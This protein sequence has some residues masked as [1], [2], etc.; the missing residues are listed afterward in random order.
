MHFPC[1][2]TLV[3][4]NYSQILIFQTEHFES[5]YSKVTVSLRN[6][7]VKSKKGKSDNTNSML[8][9]STENKFKL[10]GESLIDFKVKVQLKRSTPM[11]QKSKYL[12]I[13]KTLINFSSSDRVLTDLT[14]GTNEHGRQGQHWRKM[15]NQPGERIFMWHMLE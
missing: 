4:V 2:F 9:F 12:S 13:R 6:K 3:L 10:G 1:K 5:V 15:M 8:N 7:D 14:L 11:L